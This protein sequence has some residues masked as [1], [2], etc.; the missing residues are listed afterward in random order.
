MC[1]NKQKKTPHGHLP[2]LRGVTRKGSSRENVSI[3]LPDV[4]YQRSR[5]AL[6]VLGLGSLRLDTIYSLSPLARN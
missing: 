4:Y 5:D 3:C 2:V 6:Q 1:I